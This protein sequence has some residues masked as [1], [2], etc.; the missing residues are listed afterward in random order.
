VIGALLF[1]ATA[2]GP[3][4]FAGPSVYRASKTFHAYMSGSGAISATIQIQVSN[5]D[6][7]IYSSSWVTAAT[8]TLSGTATA[9]DGATLEGPF[10]YWRANV[11]AIS[12]TGAKVSV[13]VNQ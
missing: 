10:G 3:G 8:F 11:T 9:T 13:W 5:A 7:S 4:G 1:E 12:G 6:P 2:T